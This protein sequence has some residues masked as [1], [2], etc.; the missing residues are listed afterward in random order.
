MV[1]LQGLDVAPSISGIASVDPDVLE[2]IVV[3]EIP[4]SHVLVH[5]MGVISGV[6]VASIA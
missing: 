6:H 4:A 5:R 1:S 2:V 3:A